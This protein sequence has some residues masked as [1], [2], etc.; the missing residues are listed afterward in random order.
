MCA[1]V[2]FELFS[3]TWSC[4]D[5]KCPHVG[6]IKPNL[7]PEGRCSDYQHLYCSNAV[8]SSKETSS[9][10]WMSVINPPVSLLKLTG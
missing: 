8:N 7:L 6:I 5:A 2:L 9:A 4:C 1:T 3:A 10:T